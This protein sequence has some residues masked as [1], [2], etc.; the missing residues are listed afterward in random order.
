VKNRTPHAAT[1]DRGH[2]FETGDQVPD[3]AE[4][5]RQGELL[6]YT[7]GKEE[8]ARPFGGE[9]DVKSRR[10]REKRQLGDRII[11]GRC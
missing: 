6:T 7:T 3:L 11:E 10:N 9:E 5:G 2:K 1:H 4:R 8:G